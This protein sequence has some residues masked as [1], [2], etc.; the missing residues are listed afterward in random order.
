MNQD[1]CR[2]LVRKDETKDVSQ[3]DGNSDMISDTECGYLDG[4]PCFRLD[5]T[6]LHLQII[7]NTQSLVHTINLFIRPPISIYS[8][9]TL[10][11]SCI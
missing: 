5:I 2:L 3:N 7:V 9:Y 11:V 4:C 8:A 6:V 1:L 10:D